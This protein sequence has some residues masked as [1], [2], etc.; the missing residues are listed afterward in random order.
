M[1]THIELL[2]T[3]MSSQ[4]GK[5]KAAEPTGA[6]PDCTG[7]QLRGSCGPFNLPVCPYPHLETRDCLEQLA[8]QQRGI[9]ETVETD[10]TQALHRGRAQLVATT[11]VNLS[12]IH[13]LRKQKWFFSSSFYLFIY[14]LS[15]FLKKI[16]FFFY[17][18]IL[19]WF[20]HILTWICH[21]CTCVPHLE[22][23]SHLPPHP[24]PLGHP[25]AP[26]QSTVYRAL[27]LDWQFVSHMIIYM[28]Q[29]HSPKS[30][31]PRPL[32]QS[33]KDCSLHLCL[34]CYLAYRVIITSF[35]NSI[36]MHY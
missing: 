28:F 30:S 6:H 8:G 12:G 7:N 21:G 20:C 3:S 29:C 16:F 33:P 35:L 2:P 31:H 32:P 27:N 10:L 26:A 34:F 11:T 9:N 1:S 36:Y 19:Y 23:P 14:W 5:T 17:F 25:S 24:I 18:T 15:F 22:T 4:V 13:W